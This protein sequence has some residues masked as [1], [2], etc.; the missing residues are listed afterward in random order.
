M[1]LQEPE[2]EG[3]GWSQEKGMGEKADTCSAKRALA[4]TS[5]WW[6]RMLVL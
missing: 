3:E 4:G 2:V 1:G 5:I 6:I